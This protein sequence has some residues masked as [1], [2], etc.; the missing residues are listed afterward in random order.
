MGI[1]KILVAIERCSSVAIEVVIVEVVVR[2]YRIFVKCERNLAVFWMNY[3]RE[4]YTA[5]F[6][7]GHSTR[8]FPSKSSNLLSSLQEVSS[9]SLV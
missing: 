9:C 3:H 5:S 1:S 7:H 2:S 8:S 6:E 4:S